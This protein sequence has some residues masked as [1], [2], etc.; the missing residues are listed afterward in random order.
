MHGC[1]SPTEELQTERTWRLTAAF[2]ETA[3]GSTTA[4]EGLL[5]R[6]YRRDTEA[7]AHLHRVA[8]LATKIAEEL[9]MPAEQVADLQR[10]A[11]LHDIGRLVLPDPPALA[12]T[13]P[14]ASTLQRRAA[15][16]RTACQVA[17]DIPF[18]APAG[19]ILA[20]AV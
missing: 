13:R 18:L 3:V 2:L 7:L 12:A 9:D 8:E 1:T 6:L 19:A 20:A 4:L 5:A 17:S 14:D 11:L 10:A 15:Q 16:I